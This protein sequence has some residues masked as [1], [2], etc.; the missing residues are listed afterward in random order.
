M[1]KIDPNIYQQQKN[2]IYVMIFTYCSR[3]EDMNF[4]IRSDKLE[5]LQNTIPLLN[6]I[7]QRKLSFFEDFVDENAILEGIEDKF[8]I[9]I[10]GIDYDE[11]HW[12]KV[13][14][15]FKPDFLGAMTYS[16]KNAK[17]F[18]GELTK[19]T[20]DPF[21]TWKGASDDEYL[22]GFY[23]QN[24]KLF[25]NFNTYS[26]PEFDE[27]EFL[28]FNNFIFHNTTVATVGGVPWKFVNNN[29]QLAI[30]K[31]KKPI[32]PPK[33]DDPPT[34]KPDDPPKPDGKQTSDGNNQKGMST[35]EIIYIC[36]G[37]FFILLLIFLFIFVLLRGKRK[38][39]GKSKDSAKK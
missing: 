11:K 3:R 25:Y 23:R 8:D 14:E 27:D 35:T 12:G 36:I 5:N 13:G 26:G 34:E 9:Q 21:V 31:Y 32:N 33:P 30:E 24:G 20:N 16:P 1:L 2:G 28:K 38:S 15:L 22:L 19:L 7:Y 6:E 29:N 4:I 17:N 10:L 18:L 37:C 39:K